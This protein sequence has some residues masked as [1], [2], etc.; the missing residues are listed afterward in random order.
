[1]GK[2]ISTDYGEIEILS[3]VEVVRRRPE[4]WLGDLSQKS[5][6]ADLIFE[7]LCHALDEVLD[8]RCHYIQINIESTGSVCLQYDV[9]IPL[10][11][12]P[13]TGKSLADSIFTE[14]SACHNLKKHLHIMVGS[15][16]CQYSLATLN[17][18]CS[19]FHVN[20][21]FEGQRGSQVYFQGVAQQDFVITTCGD[22][23]GTQIKFTFD[24][25]FLGHREI[26]L[27]H[28]QSKIAKL[29]QN[30]AVKLDIFYDSNP[31]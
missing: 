22:S 11:I 9:G 10:T 13:E 25:L 3:S 14:H 28:L 26:Q 23:D 15:E 20:T 7:A 12:Y 27:A 30:F 24:E 4:M 21:V 17:A 8:G 18:V 1:M 29:R 2:I 31:V 19:E 6:L 5:L 16:Y